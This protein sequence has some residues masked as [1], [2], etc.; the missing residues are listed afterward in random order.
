MR[1][2]Y[3]S[4]DASGDGGRD[5]VLTEHYYVR[6]IDRLFVKNLIVFSGNFNYR[7][8]NKSGQ[9]VDFRPRYDVQLTSAG[10]GAG[11]SYEPYTLRQGAVL[12]SETVRRWRANAFTQPAGWPRVSHD[13][14]RNRQERGTGGVARDDW[15]SGSI[16][17]Q[18]GGMTLSSSYSRQVRT[19]I[20][21][22]GETLETYRGQA[23]RDFQLPGQGRL[24]LAYNY[25][26][27]WR[28]RQAL[29]GALDQHVPSVGL[30]MQPARW[31]G[32]NGQYTGRFIVQR[33]EGAA[34]SRTFNDQLANGSLDVTPKRG[35]AFGLLRYVERTEQRATQESRRTDYWQARATVE[36]RLFRKVRSQYTV[37]RI[38]YNGAEP[39]MRYSDAWFVSLRGRPHRH[40]ELNT[41]LGFADRHGRQ[42][43]RY[44]GNMNTNVRLYPTRQTQL[45]G[46]YNTIAEAS[47]LG[48]FD[49]SEETILAGCQYQP[50]AWLS[51]SG[52]AIWRRNRLRDPAWRRTWSATAAYRW[53]STLSAAL[54]YQNR[55]SQMASTIL[56]SEAV[57][58]QE[59]WQWT[60]D[61]WVGPS[62][63]LKLYRTIRSGGGIDSHGVWGAGVSTQF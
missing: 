5:A 42:A 17:W 45:Q 60:L 18:P 63:T 29:S 37:Y 32:W 30:A 56:E 25:D 35:L 27:T 15:N 6:A 3:Q 12:T 50:E 57:P 23:A 44:A 33:T 61:W 22:V 49:L 40:A 1:L 36:G 8:G 48:D 53:R 58:A 11:V 43:L 51:I 52:S 20:D 34:E 26:R 39:G 2:D 7:A 9:P 19:S 31:I 4:T 55:E 41:E 59:S 16:R 47:A 10:Y 38:L 62:T 13:M 54:Y 21:S 24:S 14:V 28:R 46:G